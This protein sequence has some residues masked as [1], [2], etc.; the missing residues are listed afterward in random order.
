MEGSDRAVGREEA[1]HLIQWLVV[2]ALRRTAQPD[3]P[4]AIRDDRAVRRLLRGGAVAGALATDLQLCREIL[5]PAVCAEV[6]PAMECVAV[7]TV[8]DVT[9]DAAVD[10]RVRMFVRMVTV[11]VIVSVCVAISGYLG[12]WENT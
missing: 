12:I 5:T 4:G 6:V 8:V 10:T 3:D 2:T 9:A 11:S 1:E 7:T